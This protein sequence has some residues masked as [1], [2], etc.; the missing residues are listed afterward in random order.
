MMF[1]SE[2]SHQ[3]IVEFKQASANT[4]PRL[5]HHQRRGFQEDDFIGNSQR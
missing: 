4:S 2:L 3:D 5:S 1:E